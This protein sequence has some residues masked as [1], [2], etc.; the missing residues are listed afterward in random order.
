ML[1]DWTKLKLVENVSPDGVTTYWVLKAKV[2]LLADDI[3]GMGY[4]IVAL[5][6]PASPGSQVVKFY[7]DYTRQVHEICPTGEPVAVNEEWWKA[8]VAGV[9]YEAFL[10]SS[11]TMSASLA[12]NLGLLPI[13]P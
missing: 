10:A 12:M 1:L 2:Q 5:P 6:A 11:N 3:I 4:N 13:P 7:D 9:T 8:Q